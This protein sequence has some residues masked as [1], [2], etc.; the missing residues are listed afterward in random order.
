M[1]SI[2][3]KAVFLTLV[4]VTIVSCSAQT[5]TAS[6]SRKL[7]LRILAT[8]PHDPHSFTQGLVYESGELLESAGR[9]GQSSLRRVE[10]QTGKVTQIVPQ[11]AKFFSEGITLVGGKIY[12]LTW[13]E[14]ICFVYDKKTFQL[15]KTFRY[16][17]EGW[18]ITWDGTRLIVS[19]GSSQLKF[20]NPETFQL[21]GTVV[22]RDG[23][24]TVGRLNELEYVNGE[25]WANVYETD[26][27]VRINPKN[28]RVTG[29][30]DGRGFV[31]KQ[32]R[33]IENREQV[34]N[35]IAFDPEKQ[36]VYITG[37]NWPVMYE[38]QLSQE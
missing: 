38:L 23:E 33:E 2:C 6:P 22:V 10:I 5:E 9:Y 20:Y 3:L 36:R 35:G 13:Q 27:I 7:K 1:K 19:D 4:F 30:I 8:Y 32:F 26:Y 28:G 37:K 24:R 29:W 16:K 11:D 31:P 25:V 18:G 15:T 12:Q 14:Q 21:Q 17:G 34:L